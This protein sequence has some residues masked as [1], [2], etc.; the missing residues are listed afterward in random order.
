MSDEPSPAHLA[1][2]SP[3]LHLAQQPGRALRRDLE[4]G[5]EPTMDVRSSASGKRKR[6]AQKNHGPNYYV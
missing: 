4:P 3:G 2:D 1:G 6:L 5:C